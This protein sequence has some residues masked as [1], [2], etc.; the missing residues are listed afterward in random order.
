MK[1]AV[2]DFIKN[3][4][5]IDFLLQKGWR[6]EMITKQVNEQL[7]RFFNDGQ[8]CSLIGLDLMRVYNFNEDTLR[9]LSGYML[10]V[11]IMND[12]ALRSTFNTLLGYK[13]FDC[14]PSSDMLDVILYE[15]IWHYE[16]RDETFKDIIGNECSYY[17]GEFTQIKFHK[18]SKKVFK[19]LLK[20]NKS[21]N[22][23]ITENEKT[24]IKP[25]NDFRE[26]NKN[27]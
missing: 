5:E 14:K 10:W 19:K 25:L 3:E 26:I 6:R 23:L 4:N 20:K 12:D 13:F 8:L 1:L 7:T 2:L 16:S 22:W 15:E 18:N 11:L 9:H 17:W 24:L 21:L 27:H